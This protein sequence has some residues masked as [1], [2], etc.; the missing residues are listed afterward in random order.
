MKIVLTALA[1]FFIVATLLPLLRHEAWWIRIFDFPRAQIAVAGIL[2]TV[3]Y[4]YFWDTVSVIEDVVLGILVLCVGYQVSRMIPYTAIVPHQVQDAE[5]PAESSS[6]SI[7]VVNVLMENR[8]SA[9]LLELLDAYDP[10]VIL[11]V[12]TDEWWAERL[13]VLDDEYPHVV[14]KPL[15]NTYGMMLHSRSALIDP[16]V[17]YVVDDSIP[18][19]HARIRLESGIEV[20]LHCLHPRPPYPKEDTDTEERD[21]ELL[22]V[23]REAKE[24]GGPTIVMGDLND[25]AWS[26]TTTLFQKISGLLDP[27]IGRGMY[28][29]YNANVPVLRWPLDHIF[30][31]EH[32]ELVDLERMPAWGSDHFPI[33]VRVHYSARA[34]QENEEPQADPDDEE[35]AAEKIQDAQDAE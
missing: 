1:G 15:P 3:V 16:Q 34:E 23:G 22:I 5:A 10:D 31:S 14:K 27:R 33:F 30:I 19:I 6:L 17:K 20:A 29:T 8:E 2:I 11:T 35:Q 26:Y 32:F 24:R 25:V 7:A 28:N 18:S 13:A 4:V 9:R 21:A 12:E